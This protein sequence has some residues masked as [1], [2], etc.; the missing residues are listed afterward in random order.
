MIED[1]MGQFMST[2]RR[3]EPHD[4]PDYLFDNA[5]DYLPHHLHPVLFKTFYKGYQTI[6]QGIH[7]CLSKTNL[8]LIV[9]ALPAFLSDKYDVQ[10]YLSKGGKYEYAVDAV[11]SVVKEQSPLGDSTF[12]ETWLDEDAVGKDFTG[13]V[14]CENDLEFDLVRKM[15]GLDPRLRWG[16]YNE[17]T[18]QEDIDEDVGM[19]SDDDD[20]DI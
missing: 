3:G 18:Q 20:E 7:D 14:V 12:E 6:F 19:F 2:F 11:I 9:E 8:P 1:M 10:F 15:A 4:N 5:S 13:L 16:P 17:P